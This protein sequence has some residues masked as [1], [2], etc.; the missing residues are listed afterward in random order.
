MIQHHSGWWLPSAGLRGALVAVGLL[1]L[2]AATVWAAPEQRPRLQAQESPRLASLEIGIWPEYDRPAILIILRGELTADVPLPATVP[3]TIPASSGGPSAVASSATEGGGL[4]TR[5][6]EITDA[7]DSL[8]V[9]LTTPDRLFQVEFYD[10]LPADTPDRTYSYVWPGDLAVDQLSV[11]LQEPA[12]A[13]GLSAEPD[14][15]PGTVEPDGLA[16]RTSQMGAF[17][18]GKT[19]AIEV[20]Y[21][22][23]DSRTSVEILRST[24]GTD[25]DGDVPSWLLPATIAVL[26]AVAVWVAIYWRWQRQPA[27][28][29]KGGAEGARRR[30]QRAARPQTL[31]YCTQCGHGLDP[32]DR[33]CSGCGAK[34]RRK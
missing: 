34:V 25:S 7:G 26:A 22:K 18:V 1:W 2:A 29:P 13:T 28:A 19:L 27:R 8:L 23:T 9:T 6:Y 3:L 33:F 17:E 31:A 10:L 11:R 30:D 20:S 15:G 21:R 5:S 32:G 24:A 14:L 16:Y 4:I 12:G